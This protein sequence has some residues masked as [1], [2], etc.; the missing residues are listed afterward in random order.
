MHR[1]AITPGP[2][3]IYP[4]RSRA[5]R[6]CTSRPRSLDVPAPSIQAP[7]FA[8]GFDRRKRNQAGMRR[9]CTPNMNIACPGRKSIASH[10]A[11]EL[12][13]PNLSGGRAT[14][15]TGIALVS[16]VFINS[17]LVLCV[18]AKCCEAEPSGLCAREVSWEAQSRC[19]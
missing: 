18:H 12:T 5:L 8:I 4:G 1:L 13:T 14:S 17:Q 19:L 9:V 6:R 10:T 3:F 7:T 2:G 15:H 11:A 16:N